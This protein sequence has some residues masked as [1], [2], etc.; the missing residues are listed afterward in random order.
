MNTISFC[1]YQF[2]QINI[3]ENQYSLKVKPVYAELTQEVGTDDGN[4]AALVFGS[5]TLYCENKRHKTTTE[6][7]H[8]NIVGP[9]C[10]MRRLART[11]KCWLVETIISR[12]FSHKSI[13]TGMSRCTT[14]RLEA[15]IYCILHTSRWKAY[16]GCGIGVETISS[17]ILRYY[18][19][20]YSVQRQGRS[21]RVEAVSVVLGIWK[22]IVRNWSGDCR[23]MKQLTSENGQA[24]IIILHQTSIL[25]LQQLQGDF[26]SSGSRCPK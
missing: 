3:T 9:R 24:S 23:V 20:L 10:G 4:A 26:T 15:S 5:D 22:G 14:R 8:L 12:A 6:C 19:V 13:S 21:C 11:R 1:I 18:N 17:V 2:L 25:E 7:V 16:G